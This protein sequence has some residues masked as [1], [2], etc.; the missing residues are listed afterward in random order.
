MTN[1]RILAALLL[2]A[3]AVCYGGMIIERLPLGFFFVGTA[4][5]VVAGVLFWIA[6]PSAPVAVAAPRAVPTPPPPAPT[7]E[8]RVPELDLD[9]RDARAVDRDP[10]A[11]PSRAALEPPAVDDEDFD[12]SSAI[13]LPVEIQDERK[14]S[15]QLDKLRRLLESGHLTQ[16]EYQ[17]AKQKLLG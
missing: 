16:D 17:V 11:R 12:A 7:V 9:E 10:G 8:M 13:S 4:C 5:Y 1:G 3:G 14:I 2:L 15:D 6:R